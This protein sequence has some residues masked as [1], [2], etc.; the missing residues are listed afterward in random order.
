MPRRNE[1]RGYRRK[2]ITIMDAQNNPLQP[3]SLPQDSQLGK[4]N[5]MANMKNQ[6]ELMQRGGSERSSITDQTQSQSKKQML[7]NAFNTDNIRVST[8]LLLFINIA[9]IVK[10]GVLLAFVIIS[11]EGIDTMFSQ[12]LKNVMNL[13]LKQVFEYRLA[14]D[15]IGSFY[16]LAK[17][18]NYT[19][20]QSRLADL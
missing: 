16:E 12:E 9:V 13:S 14:A 6:P 10:F 11:I 15:Q 3:E 19:L 1:D 20:E 4:F 18:R 2:I 17:S 7:I 8:K 5:E